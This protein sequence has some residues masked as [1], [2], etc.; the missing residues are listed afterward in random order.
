[1]ARSFSDR[2]KH[3]E[4]T[5]NPNDILQTWLLRAMTSDKDGNK[6]KGD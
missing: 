5:A 6:D 1:M 3:S 2:S 4:H